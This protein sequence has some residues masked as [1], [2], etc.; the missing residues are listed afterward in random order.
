MPAPVFS[1]NCLHSDRSTGVYPLGQPGCGF[2]AAAVAA[3]TASA[4]AADAAAIPADNAGGTADPPSRP[5]LRT[6]VWVEAGMQHHL[7]ALGTIVP[8]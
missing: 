1:V 6:M 2:E 3:A 5:A 4:A 7:H 8:D